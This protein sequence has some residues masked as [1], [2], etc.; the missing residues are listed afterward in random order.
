MAIEHLHLENPIPINDTDSPYMLT[1]QLLANHAQ[2]LQILEPGAYD[3][4]LKDTNYE[5]EPGAYRVE[6]HE[7]GKASCGQILS[8]ENAGQYITHP[9]R[10]RL[11]QPALYI[12][13]TATQIC[14]VAMRK[15]NVYRHKGTPHIFDV[16]RWK[17]DDDT[18]PYLP[19]IAVVV[20]NAA[21][22]QEL[23]PYIGKLQ[24][25]YKA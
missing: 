24:R 6:V 19:G 1:D 22:A 9:V 8:S 3:L 2:H 11:E 13:D 23:R 4:T 17:G 21:A 20:A 5:H 16:L 12:P 14:I 25:P 7:D 10:G 15:A 18:W